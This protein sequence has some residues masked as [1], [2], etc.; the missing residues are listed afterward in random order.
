ML[1]RALPS[2]GPLAPHQ[3]PPGRGNATC[4][5]MVMGTLFPYLYSLRPAFSLGLSIP[6]QTPAP[7]EGRH[8]SAS[9]AH[10]SVGKAA[11]AKP[12][13]AVCALE[14]VSQPQG[15]AGAVSTEP[16]SWGREWELGQRCA[17]SCPGGKG[18]HKEGSPGPVLRGLPTPRLGTPEPG[19][20]GS[21]R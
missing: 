20:S 12:V 1:V 19:P 2:V 8:P 6:C 3:R 21:A 18:N 9:P 11:L 16:P 17:Y 7:G 10:S 13:S 15:G 14:H 5:F 4:I